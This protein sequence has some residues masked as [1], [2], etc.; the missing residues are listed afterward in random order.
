MPK[1][2]EGSLQLPE[3]VQFRG[4]DN[5]TITGI[6]YKPHHYEAGTKYP[7]VLWIHGGPE[8][9]DE[10]R[11]DPW[12]QFL[13]QEGYLVLEPNYRGSTG[14]G[15]K[16][17][18]LNVEDSGGG[19]MDDVAAGAHYLIDH[20]LADPKRIAI[21]GGSHGGTM[22]AYAVARYPQLFAAAI[23]M[24]GVVDRATFL[25]RTNPNSA[26]RW[27]MKMGGYPS[28][29]PEVYRKAN[30]LL[31]VDKIQTPLLILHGENDPQV[32]PYE[33]IQFVKELAAH[34]KTYY[35]FTYPNEL[36]GFSQREHRSMPGTRN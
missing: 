17:R 27:A 23:E 34:H 2:F 5:L 8:G 14:Y 11:L 22:T 24:Y 36:H 9:Q 12:A 35:Y 32:P 25:E 19:E 3:R 31:L 6:L 18:N 21:G 13:A 4:K 1:T 28:E 7:A 10:F 16:F 29:K 33:S 20:G 15:E 26:V 30:S